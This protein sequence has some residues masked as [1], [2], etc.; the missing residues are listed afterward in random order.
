MQHDSNLSAFRWNPNK[1]QADVVMVIIGRLMML[2]DVPTAKR[3]QLNP[4][5]NRWL[6]GLPTEWDACAPT[7]TPSSRKSRKPS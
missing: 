2:S 3:A 6:M 4:A 1:K 5:F 7:A